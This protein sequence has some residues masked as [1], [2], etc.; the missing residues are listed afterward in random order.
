VR[1]LLAGTLRISEFMADNESGLRD[2]DGDRSDWI[3]IQNTGLEAVDLAG[4]RLTDDADDLNGWTFPS[5]TLAAG[6]YLTLFASG[7]N[8]HATG[9]LGQL[10]T[11]FSLGQEGEY[12]ALVQPDGT[13]VAHQFSPY[14]PQQRADVSFGTGQQMMEP[15]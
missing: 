3:E 10:H 12:L 8:R 7:K 15:C 6:D 4:W 11:D 14:Y 5:R 2:E 13:T 9:P 1:R